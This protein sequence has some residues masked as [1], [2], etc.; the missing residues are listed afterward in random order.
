MLGEA[1]GSTTIRLE[2][3]AWNLK[4][5]NIP[6]I[7]GRK[8]SGIP[9]RTGAAESMTATLPFREIHEHLT[10]LGH[11]VSCSDD[12]GRYLCNQLFF[13]ALD[14][15]EENTVNIPAGFIHLPL[16]N[17]LPTSDATKAI[18]HAIRLTQSS[19]Q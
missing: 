9:I 7:A 2:T 18:A 8:P 12:P 4:D 6:D 3:T 15:L 1:A 11:P 5:F 17:D 16:E 14:F 13:S 10:S 19:D